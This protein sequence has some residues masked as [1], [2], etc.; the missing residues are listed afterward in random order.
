MCE[1]VCG[2]AGGHG[3]EDASCGAIAEVL[4]SSGRVFHHECVAR[5]TGSDWLCA[6]QVESLDLGNNNITDKGVAAIAS[7]DGFRLAPDDH[8]L[9]LVSAIELCTTLT[10]VVL[11]NNR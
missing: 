10:Q 3:I 8:L 11:R 9:V 5:V 6:R 7:G 2:M 4:Q 1:G